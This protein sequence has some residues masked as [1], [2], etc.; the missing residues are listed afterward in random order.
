[1]IELENERKPARQEGKVKLKGIINWERMAWILSQL[2]LFGYIR[3]SRCHVLQ[4]GLV[5]SPGELSG[6]SQVRTGR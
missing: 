3:S 2:S 1:M 6:S 5:T 4:T